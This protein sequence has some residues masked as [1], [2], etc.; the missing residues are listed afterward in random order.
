[1]SI[2]LPDDYKQFLRDY[3][4]IR[5]STFFVKDLNKAIPLDILYGLGVDQSF[6]LFAWN[7]EY[8]DDLIPNSIIIGDDPGLF[9]CW[10][11]K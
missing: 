6:D 7:E 9:S 1:M 8:K 2:S 5:Y 10:S 3:A 11:R 4:K